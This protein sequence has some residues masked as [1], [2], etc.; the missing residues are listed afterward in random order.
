AEQSLPPSAWTPFATK[1]GLAFSLATGWSHVAF[2]DNFKILKRNVE[3][4]PNTFRIIREVVGDDLLG[5]R[6][7]AIARQNA[8]TGIPA[9]SDNFNYMLTLHLPIR[10][11]CTGVGITINGTYYKYEEGT[12]LVMDTTFPH[13]TINECESDAI[14]LLVDFFHSDLTLDEREAL[15]LFWKFNSGI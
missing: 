4:L 5:P 11:S 15:R 6:H 10:C 7:V 1:K 12:P 13:A 8:H 3:L 2:V 14:I 9:H